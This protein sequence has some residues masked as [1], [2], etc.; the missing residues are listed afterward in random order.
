MSNI[1]MNPCYS[2]AMSFMRTSNKLQI[3]ES[4]IEKHLDYCYCIQVLLLKENNL[5]SC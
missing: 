3:G 2:N 1:A 4:Q 5:I